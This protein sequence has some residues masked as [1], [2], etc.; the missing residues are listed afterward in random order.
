MDGSLI[1]RVTFIWGISRF[2][3]SPPWFDVVSRFSGVSGRAGCFWV[4]VNVLAGNGFG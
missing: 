1:W 2:L 3:L 4:F